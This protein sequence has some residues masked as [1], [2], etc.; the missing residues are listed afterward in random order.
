MRR[1]S[2]VIMVTALVLGAASMAVAHNP[3][4][5][6][7]FAVH[8]PDANLPVIDG[9]LEDWAPVPEEYII[10]SADL[11]AR[12]QTLPTG[13]LGRGESDPADHWV[14]H[15]HGFNANTNKLYFGTTVWDNYHDNAREDAAAIWVDDDWEVRI[16]PSAVDPEFQNVAGEPANKVIYLSGVPPNEGVYMRIVPG[17]EYDFMQVGTE[18]LQYGWSY[19]GEMVGPGDSIYIYEMALRPVEA[20][21]ETGATLENTVFS[22]LEEGDEVHIANMVLDCDV[23][24]GGHNGAWGLH[25]GPYNNPAAD[26][27]MAEMDDSI[28]WPTAVENVSWGMIKAGLAE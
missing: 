22:D 23:P 20:L 17:E 21:L 24:V 9:Y 4:G 28:E 5:E 18:Q 10:T 3:P 13:N 12:D 19:T 14:K 6:T 1:F 2:A 7:F 15:Y 27:I 25:A 8:I 26:F 16:N 11:F